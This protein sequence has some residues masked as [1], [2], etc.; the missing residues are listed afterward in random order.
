VFFERKNQRW[1]ALAEATIE[2]A[3]SGRALVK[4]LSVT[5]CRLESAV[6]MHINTGEVYMI[7]VYPEASANIAEFELKAQVQWI[8]SGSAGCEAGFSIK[9]SP[10]GAFFNRYIDYLDYRASF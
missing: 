1:A 7:V 10:K 8:E 6:P 4:D 5:G 2:G 9:V 3:F